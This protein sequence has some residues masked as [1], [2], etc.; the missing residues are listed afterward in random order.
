ML[1]RKDFYYDIPQEL[2]A[3]T[4]TS[5]RDE[6]RLLVCDARTK[7]V[8][9]RNF[10]EIAQVI[11]EKLCMNTEKVLLIVND[12]RVY[13]ARVR[14]KRQTGAR[15][16]VFLLE[17]GDKESYR[18]LLRPQSKLKVGEIL[19]SDFDNSPIFKV[20]NLDSPQVS[21]FPSVQLQSILD[22]YGEM[23]LPPYIERDPKRV[24]DKKK[25]DKERYQTVYSDLNKIG[26]AAAPTAGLHFTEKTMLECK[27]MGIEFV[28]V[29]LH[30]GLGTFSPVQ[31]DELNTHPMHEEHYFLSHTTL[32]KILD[33]KKNNWPIIYVGTT[34]LR[35]VESFFRNTI[36]NQKVDTWLP[37]KL[38]LYPQGKDDKI[39][40]SVG[41][42]IITNFHQPESTL[43]ML[44][45]AL[46]GY[47]FWKEFY[48]H[49]IEN[50][51]RFFSYGDS[52]LLIF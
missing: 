35:A 37:T 4:P 33:Y 46:M 10:R 52:S 22:K 3:Q 28:S 9:D 11:K 39:K 26:S 20:T 6:S 14:I 30:V 48:M 24:K 16:E 17:T 40:P 29:T 36:E 51:Y 34:S 45:A 47:N 31:V 13:P 50:K 7:F 21:L 49:A 43:A 23:P 15:G 5:N 2:I 8:E 1:L 44:V 18:C 38:F 42:A 25:L 27:N 19:Y 12:S 32:N 41:N